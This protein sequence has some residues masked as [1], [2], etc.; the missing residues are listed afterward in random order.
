MSSRDSAKAV[1]I[2]RMDDRILTTRLPDRAVGW[3]GSSLRERPQYEV[4]VRA[5]LKVL[6][7]PLSGPSRALDDRGPPTGTAV[8]VFQG[9]FARAERERGRRHRECGRT[10]IRHDFFGAIWHHGAG[11]HGLTT[12]TNGMVTVHESR[13]TIV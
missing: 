1:A 7:S 4:S 11:S 5:V 9:F 2:A 6:S 8:G 3:P 13:V 10:A 12:A